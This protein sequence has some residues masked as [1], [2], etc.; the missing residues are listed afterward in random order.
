M[1]VC[2]LYLCYIRII[3][4]AM[5][6]VLKIKYTLPLLNIINLCNVKGRLLLYMRYQSR[7]LF[8]I[9]KKKKN[10]V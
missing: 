9:K 2:R 5:C 1:Y 8:K 7:T 10:C 3:Q 4:C 6:M